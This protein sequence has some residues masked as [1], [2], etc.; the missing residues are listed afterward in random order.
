MRPLEGTHAGGRPGLEPPVSAD[1]QR[2]P[3]LEP[4][5]LVSPGWHGAV[6]CATRT[7]AS[8]TSLV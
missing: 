1:A 2:D 5:E 6:L 8:Q 7:S 4:G 3:D